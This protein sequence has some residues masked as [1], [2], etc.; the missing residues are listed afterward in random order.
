VQCASD[1]IFGV[2][3]DFTYVARLFFTIFYWFCLD[4]VSPSYSWSSTFH[5]LFVLSVLLITNLALV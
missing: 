2:P 1:V 5:S 4:M 3:E